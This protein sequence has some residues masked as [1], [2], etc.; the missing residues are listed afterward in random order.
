ME[1]IGVGPVMD[2]AA[3]DQIIAFLAQMA[4]YTVVLK[5]LSMLTCAFILCN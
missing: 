5:H 2:R 4:Q 3:A 1:L